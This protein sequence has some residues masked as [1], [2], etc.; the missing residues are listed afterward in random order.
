MPRSPC[1]WTG[2]GRNYVKVLSV[3][4]KCLAN[5]GWYEYDFGDGWRAAVIVT[6]VDGKTARKL[7]KESD[8]FAGYEWMIDEIRYLGR[9][10]TLSEKQASKDDGREG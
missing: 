9:I 8:G 1:E 5:P 6:E 4:N 7:R 2:V 10:R 3:K